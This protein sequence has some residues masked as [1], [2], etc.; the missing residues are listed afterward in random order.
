MLANAL[1]E[2]MR[3]ESEYKALESSI[4]QGIETAEKALPVLQDFLKN[5]NDQKYK[6]LK[7]ISKGFFSG[8]SDDKELRKNLGMIKRMNLKLSPSLNLLTHEKGFYCDTERFSPLPDKGSEEVSNAAWNGRIFRGLSKVNR[9]HNVCYIG[10]EQ[11]EKLKNDK[12]LPDPIKASCKTS[13]VLNK[14]KDPVRHTAMNGQS[15][16]NICT[17]AVEEA[18]TKW[19]WMSFDQL[20][21][22]VQ[23]EEFEE[24]A[25]EKRVKPV[26]AFEH[27]FSKTMLHEVGQLGGRTRLLWYTYMD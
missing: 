12:S 20:V 5:I 14:G 16:I 27:S 2:E 25:A 6:H 24:D 22:F 8:S 9:L 10:L 3:T 26:W 15:M 21:D 23:T 13:D 18:S 19:K 4:G 7:E 17:W 11:A 1:S